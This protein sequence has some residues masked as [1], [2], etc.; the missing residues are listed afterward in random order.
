MLVGQNDYALSTFGPPGRKNVSKEHL[1]LIFTSLNHSVTTKQA[2]DR[3]Q[4]ICAGKDGVELDT[5][6]SFLYL[7]HNCTP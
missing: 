7:R 6:A 3:V 2:A 5:L 4:Q 1:T